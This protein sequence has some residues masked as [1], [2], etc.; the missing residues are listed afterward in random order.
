MS[1][2]ESLPVGTVER[3]TPVRLSRFLG[4]RFG[5]K[6]LG[7]P[8]GGRGGRSRFVKAS[9]VSQQS[10]WSHTHTHRIGAWCDLYAGPRHRNV[11]C[12]KE[13]AEPLV[14]C[15][16]IIK[17]LNAQFTARA[18]KSVNVARGAIL[19][20]HNRC[21]V[22]ACVGSCD[23]LFF[24][25]YFWRH[26]KCIRGAVTSAAKRKKRKRKKRKRK[27]DVMNILCAA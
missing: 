7:R 13:F 10:L 17:R 22:C 9:Y 26:G 21:L 23:E 16:C 27:K 2:V 4:S 18:S 5:L 15:Y 6:Q 12:M 25:C 1:Q 20:A 14:S 8:G 3:W 11:R 19:V 24:G